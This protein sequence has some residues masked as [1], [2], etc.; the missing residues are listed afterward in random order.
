MFSHSEWPAVQFAQTM[1]SI[2]LLDCVLFFFQFINWRTA[3]LCPHNDP[4]WWF[5]PTYAPD[6]SAA[7]TS[8]DGPTA[9][10]GPLNRESVRLWNIII[11]E[12]LSTYANNRWWWWWWCYSVLGLEVLRRVITAW[13]W[14]VVLLE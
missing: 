9:V 13:H 2:S 5:P 8:D 12:I 1:Q 11:I 10:I 6:S 3:R 7:Y 4:A 14:Q